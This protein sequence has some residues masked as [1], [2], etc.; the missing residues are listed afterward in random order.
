M[1][2]VISTRLAQL[3]SLA[4]ELAEL[5]ATIGREFTFDVL[6][7]ALG[8]DEEL[9]VRGLDE[10]WQ[11]RIVRE[12]G[13][14]A[15][16]FCHGKIRDTA[17]GSLSAAR[18]R[19]LHRRVAEALQAVYADNLDSVSAQIA[20][21]YEQAG[22]PQQAIAH[23]RRA[24]EVAR[25]MCANDKAIALLTR[26]LDL[27]P[28]S[29]WAQRC[30]LLLAREPIYDV[31]GMRELQLGDITDSQAL[32]QAL[33][34]G[35]R[36]AEATL[37]LAR[38][39]EAISDYEAAIE[40]A[41]IVIRLSQATR[42]VRHEAAGYL[43]WGRALWQHGD[44]DRAHERLEQA[45]ELAQAAHALDVGAD[46]LCNLAAV[47]EYRGNHVSAR[48]RFGQALRLYR[49][50]GDRHG[51]SRALNN[52]GVASI[53]LG[54][55][56]EA[57]TSFEQALH[58]N[59]ELGARKDESIVLRNLGA[60]ADCRGDYAT[61]RT[62]YE[63]SLQL[64]RA[65]GERRG[66]SETLTYLGLLFHHLGNHQTACE[67]SQQAVHIAQQ[68]GA[69]YEQGLALTH[70][71]H[72]LLSLGQL[73]QAA[74][75]YTQA[76]TIRR[77]LGDLDLVMEPLAGLALALLAQNDLPQ[78]QAHI[79][80][81]LSHVAHSSLDGAD[82]PF[83]VYWACYRVLQ[84]TRDP[85]AMN[86]LKIAYDLLQAQ[87]AQMPDADA[88]RAF[89]TNVTVHREIIRAWRAIEEPSS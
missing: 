58:L 11:R 64:C 18:K 31:Q 69:K 20:T 53:C 66:E 88:R 6:K 24:A 79:E 52:L 10:L 85:R 44:Y 4:R 87:V 56:A 47:A 63:Q 80:E 28:A 1:Q 59:R 42:D 25:R 30:D 48:D 68:V 89:L 73:G 3:S 27:T 17:Y 78:A 75:A 34:D 62:C 71:G 26:A 32:A 45:I 46:S 2:A 40:A 74:D 5:A 51:E 36:Q 38:Y 81:I 15:Y 21:H 76:L 49:A 13:K 86:V 50:L 61:A 7:Q 14:D 70:L 35:Q 33:R 65:I 39:A 23:Y 77:T 57:Q 82:E 12:H 67:H 37:R 55:R 8:G 43:Q 54:D 72:A 22:L 19:L 16:D 84:A 29:D 60:L 9:L 83:R 41:Q